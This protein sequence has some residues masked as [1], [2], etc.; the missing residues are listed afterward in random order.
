MT[1]PAHYQRDQEHQAHLQN[2]MQW[3]DNY[4]RQEE[5]KALN[6]SGYTSQYLSVDDY[7][8]QR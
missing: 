6:I 3:M 8:E 4:N 2:W 5:Q 1:D 7:Q